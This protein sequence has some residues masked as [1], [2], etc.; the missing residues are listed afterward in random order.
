MPKKSVPP[1]HNFSPCYSPRPAPPRPKLFKEQR[2]ELWDIINAGKRGI[3]LNQLNS[4]ISLSS[5]QIR[6]CNYQDYI[7]LE[8]S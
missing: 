1:F 2:L 4:F 8:R 3:S 7:K 6:G 5:F